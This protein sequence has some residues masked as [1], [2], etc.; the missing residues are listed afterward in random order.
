[1]KIPGGVWT[2][3]FVSLLM[4][5]SSELIHAL[6]P[7][8]MVGALGASVLVVG[9]IE[10][11]AE[12][13]ALIIKVFS[14]YWSDV[15]R[16]R[17]R[18]VVLGYGLAAVSKL[19]FPLAPT[20]GW[21]VA[22]RFADRVGKGI[23]GAPRDALIADLTPASVRGAAFG[24]RQALDTVG[25]IAGPLLAVAAIGYFAGDFRAAFWVAIVPAALCVALLVFGVHESRPSADEPDTGATRVSWRDA[26]RLDRRF[27]I[28]T[29]IAFVLTLA[30][31]SEAF[32]VLRAQDVGM[33]TTGAP[34][35]MVAMSIVYAAIA[36]PAGRAA[37]RGHATMLLSAGLVALVVSDIVLALAASAAG[38]LAGAALWGLH[39]A[40]TQGLLAA[41]IAATA[42][43]DLRG[44]AFGVFNLASGIALLAGERPCRVPLAIGRAG[45]HVPR[46][47]RVHRDCM[48]GAHASGV[49]DP[50]ARRQSLKDAAPG[51]RALV[52]MLATL[53]ERRKRKLLASATTDRKPRFAH[54][55]VSRH[56]PPNCARNPADERAREPSRP[57]R[58]GRRARACGDAASSLPSPCT[59]GAHHALDQRRCIDADVHERAADLQFA[60]GALLGRLVLQQPPRV[61]R[62]RRQGAG[63]RQS[64]RLCARA[65]ARVQHDRRARPVHRR[66]P[67]VRAG[68]SVV[69]YGAE[70]P[71]AR[72]GP[73]VA[74]LLCVGVSHQR[75]LLRRLCA[76][77]PPPRAGPV[78]NAAKIF[79]ASARRSSITCGSGTR[80]AKRRSATTCCRNLPT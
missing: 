45:R 69:A 17:K 77:E 73:I 58:R 76:L 66:R 70:P 65:R 56:G 72:D 57:G 74:F 67:D 79:V 19:A 41:L 4:D 44:T 26:R 15:T 80:P 7:L 61:A 31:F 48:G 32:L 24:L 62:N 39:M 54:A 13:L 42:P 23:R 28:V 50:A 9:L 55:V 71:M 64:G 3:G 16:H 43:E 49:A 63:G 46:R 22:A 36:F 14:G 59:A 51:R 75:P 37:D 21:I 18:L 1:M 47:R 35:V 34:W 5:T 2:L 10:G 30:R 11:F 29:A 68:V 12:A 53:L 40:L 27:H 25:A 20:L 8:Y 33:G 78:A 60:P 6:L 38:V 52:G